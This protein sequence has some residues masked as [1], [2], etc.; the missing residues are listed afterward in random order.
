MYVL[1]ST[2]CQH[3]MEHQSVNEEAYV[4]DTW[5]SCVGTQLLTDG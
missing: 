4:L 5:M 2:G 1:T 3:P